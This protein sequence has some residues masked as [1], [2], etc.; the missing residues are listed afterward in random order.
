M[1]KRKKVIDS[2]YHC[3]W[4][5]GNTMRC[6]HPLVVKRYGAA[7]NDFCIVPVFKCLNCKFAVKFQFF[8]GVKCG[9]EE[10]GEHL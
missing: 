10:E 8:G 5:E 9:Y 3:E 2:I 6:S 1:D 7:G 4:D